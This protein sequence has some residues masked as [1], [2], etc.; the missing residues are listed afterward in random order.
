MWLLLLD[1]PILCVTVHCIAILSTILLCWLEG[2]GLPI[3]LDTGILGPHLVVASREGQEIQVC[4]KSIS[5][6]MDVSGMDGLGRGQSLLQ[7]T[8]PGLCFVLFSSRCE[9][10]P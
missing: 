7:F 8:V 2:E 10:Q 4:W 5:L 1:S 3:S 9:P 6:A